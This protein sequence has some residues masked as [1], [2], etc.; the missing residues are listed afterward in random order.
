MKTT[1]A[2]RTTLLAG[3]ALAV[4]AG[5]VWSNPVQAQVQAE[6]QPEAAVQS[7]TIEDI[8]VTAQ[9]REQSINSVGMAIQAFSGEALDQLHITD[10]RDLQTVAPSFTVTQ[11]YH[12][13]PIYTLRGIGFNTINLSSTSTVG[14]YV[15]EAAYAYP[16]MLNAPIFDLQRVE[17]LKGPQGTLYG[18][19]T[20]AGLVDFIT[21][22]PTDHFE[23]GTTVEVGNYDT[24]N[25]EGFVSGPL[26]E[27]V[28]A[29]LAVRKE[30]SDEG[31]QEDV[32][33]GEKL[34]EVD[35][36]AAR[37]R[38][39]WT[40]T[41]RLSFNFSAS[42]WTNDSDT[43][44]GQ[45]IGFTPNTDPALGGRFAPFNTP[46]LVAYIGANQPRSSET[47]GFAP[48][49]TR[50]ATIGGVAGLGGELKEDDT[51][52]ALALRSTLDLSDTM[53]IVALTSYN[54]LQREALSD[55]SGSPYEIMLQRLEGE[56]RSFSQELRIE[57]R[58]DRVQWL[59]GGY[60]GKDDL[61]DN[62]E[63]IMGQNANVGAIRYNGSLLLG[64]PFNSG[65]YTAAQMAASFRGFRDLGT[66][67][68][69]TK[70]IFANAEWTL[71]DTLSLTTGLRFTN[72]THDYVG[73]SADNNGSMLPNVNVVNRY[74][75]TT[76]YGVTPAPISINQCNTYDPAA[77]QFQEG[78][79]TVDEDNV[80][81]RLALDWQ[82]APDT[83]I[84]AS[85]S[86]GA[87]AGN[88]PINAANV[89]TQNSP[90]LQET[91]LAYELGTKARLAGGALQLNAAAFYYDYSDKQLSVYF[92]DPIYTA[93]RRLQNVPESRAYG[94]ELDATWR[95]TPYL[96]FTG[97]ALNLTTEVIG[98]DGINASGLA[99]TYD[100]VPFP[101][102]PEWQLSATANFD[103][104]VSSTLGVS[105]NL[106]YR[107]QSES[108]ADLSEGPLF[109]MDAY[110]TLNAN[111]GV[112]ALDGRWK[113]N[114][115]ARNL[116]DEYYWTSVSSNA[117]LVV[118]FA[119]RPRTFGLN[120]SLAY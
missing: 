3:T 103:A 108:A 112:Y 97:S 71:T 24:L 82:V 36:L 86:Q 27:T 111:V 8:V 37:L 55:W 110:G 113:V 83:L 10:V 18:R 47:A 56:A 52:Y 4:F 9:R 62:N 70:S 68:A 35:R 54:N 28:N 116:T 12:G 13:V 80:S 22:S 63:T 77:G 79:H 44:A 115:W 32:A 96:T 6:A 23:A 14:S 1:L 39:D 65:G 49:S 43:M 7:T 15:D 30:T 66:I 19:N 105:G 76:L 34:G 20:T 72:D 101:N 104:P 69:E 53:S 118:R 5:L 40:P 64:T 107:W 48:V 59:I 119:G 46:G 29:R 114:V 26:G 99:Q 2:H 93:L 17:I 57:G 42:G 45:A 98:Y 117:N 25:F 61:V 100:G 91:L 58:N 74:L 67:E 33:S 85:V 88:T 81:W 102:S 50:G 95:A 73:C 94:L 87:K 92:A 109:E 38:I 11:G 51:F 89:S 90:A 60:Y 75:I 16:F 31:W 21:N 84:Y 106:N 120:L 41:D 78:R